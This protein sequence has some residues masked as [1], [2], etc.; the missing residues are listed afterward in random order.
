MALIRKT[1]NQN[2]F[3]S[4]LPHKQHSGT[5]CD[6]LICYQVSDRTLISVR[7]VKDQFHNRFIALYNFNDPFKFLTICKLSA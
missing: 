2:I 1:V 7:T 5:C 4:L 6:R 3:I